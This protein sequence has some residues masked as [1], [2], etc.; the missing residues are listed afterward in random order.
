MRGFKRSFLYSIAKQKNTRRQQT[1]R[2]EKMTSNEILRSG[3]DNFRGRNA[4][5]RGT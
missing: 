4:R 5:D 3:N 1:L 2:T